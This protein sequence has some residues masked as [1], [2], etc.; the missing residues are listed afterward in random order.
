MSLKLLNLPALGAAALVSL[1]VVV[2]FLPSLREKP[3]AFAL[4]VTLT[5]TTAGRV[6]VYWDRGSGYSEYDSS[7]LPVPKGGPPAVYRLKITSGTYRSLRFDPI[8]GDGT[9]VLYSANIVDR[10]GRMIRRVPLSDFSRLNQIQSLDLRG[11]VLEVGIVPGGNDPQLLVRFDPPLVPPYRLLSVAREALTRA[12][13]VLAALVLVLWVLERM[14]KVRAALMAAMAGLARRPRGLVA[15]VSALAV[16][17]SAYPVVFGG[18]SYVA[19]N[20]DGVRLLYDSDSTLPGYGLTP[21]TN[22][23]GSDVGA[24]FWSHIPLSMI[25]HRALARDGEWPLWN[26]Y[27][28][29]GVPLLGQ[30]QSMF[31]DPLHLLVVAANGAAWAWDLK[32]LA[33]KW[34]LATGLG[35]LVL[36]VAGRT[37]A[38][39]IVALA[40]PFFGFFVYRFNHPAFFSFCYAPWPLDCWI[41]ASGAQNARS[42]GAWAVALVAAN[43]A[44]MNS[45]TVKEAYML[46]VSM[47]FSGLCVAVSARAPLGLRMRKLAMIAWG[48]LLFLM[49][50]A[51]VWMTFLATLRR[52]YT[53]YDTVSAFQIQP[54]LLIG[55]FDEAFFRPLTRGDRVQSLGKLPDPS[56]RP[57]F[58]GHAQ[59]TVCK[60]DRDR[61]GLQLLC[62]AGPGLRPGPC[63][64]DCPHPVPRECRPY[65][66]LLHLRPDHPLVGHCGG[67]FRHGCGSP[68]KVRRKG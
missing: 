57:L 10:D 45:G 68:G 50:T 27:D 48:Q 29:C 61:P 55:A 33:A 31:G 62:S 13:G 6:Q 11:G 1:A 39:A 20:L 25:E 2:P 17:V 65:R 67:G 28:S 66:Q 5:S 14:V 15:L 44:L 4:E 38:A 63:A 7:F 16:V 47:N 9:V 49:I 8:D 21:T 52:S 26:R 22:V 34:L 42:T 56:G 32:Y 3:D 18:K 12:A 36:A 54:S 35:L 37:S 23:K 46:L 64:L 60:P 30:G 41:R 58:P 43:I 53:S 40:A 19:P 24:V 59:G 51:P